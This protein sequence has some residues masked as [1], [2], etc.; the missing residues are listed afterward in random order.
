MP[1]H[2]YIVHS[3]PP[4]FSFH[5]P[6]GAVSHVNS[7]LLGNSGCSLTGVCVAPVSAQSC[8]SA[9]S[10]LTGYAQQYPTH[11]AL[12]SRIPHWT[13]PTNKSWYPDTGVTH[14]VTHDQSNLQT[15]S[16]YTCNSKLLM[17][18]GD[19]IQISHIG[20]GSLYT[21]GK[22]L[23]LQ[24]LLHIPKFRKNLLSISQLV[25]DNDVVF[26]CHANVCFV[27]DS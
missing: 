11:V 13:S 15:T 23:V 3:P 26:E 12:V 7:E 14:H 9:L 24:N 17:E 21:C 27:K 16:P 20:Q 25:K 1:S 19:G 6:P 5:S 18:N 2:Q 4:G 10:S 8:G 22:P